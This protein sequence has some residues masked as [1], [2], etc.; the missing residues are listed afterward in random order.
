[1]I[2]GQGEF[3]GDLEL[4]NNSKQYY[5]SL[6]CGSHNSEIYF[7]DKNVFIKLNLKI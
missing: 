3:F 6:R 4:K 2:I 7:C 5:F 1:M